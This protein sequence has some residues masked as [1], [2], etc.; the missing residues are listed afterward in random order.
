VLS[1]RALTSFTRGRLW[2]R[3]ASGTVGQVKL[4]GAYTHLEYL[5]GTGSDSRDCGGNARVASVASV[6]A[7]YPLIRS[8]DNNL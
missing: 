3:V 6:Y 1:L 4:D 5:L 7:S 8:R 2:T